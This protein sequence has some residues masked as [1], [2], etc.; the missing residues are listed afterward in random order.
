MSLR[1]NMDPIKVLTANIDKPNS[2]SIDTYL[3]GGGYEAARK[4]LTT[5][6]WEEVIQVVKDS[7]L[8]GRGGAGFPTGMK[9]GFVP[10]N[11][12]RP[13]YLLCNADESEPGTF[14][15]RV[16]IE[17]DPHLLIEGMIITAFAIG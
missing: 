7:E 3:A 8:R 15:D 14:K 4:A 13:T 5:M 10:R 9:W 1:A 6:K 16:I 12:P 2:K 17:Q 11:A